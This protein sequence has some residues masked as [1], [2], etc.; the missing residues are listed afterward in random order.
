MF[1]GRRKCQRMR[2]TLRQRLR[3][4]KAI[5]TLAPAQPVVAF[6][7]LQT[8]SVISEADMRSENPVIIGLISMITG[9]TDRESIEKLYRQCLLRGLEIMSAPGNGMMTNPAIISLLEKAK[10]QSSKTG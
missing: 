10:E 5:S 6:K 2:R 1:C 3:R 7:G 8:A 9:M 4:Q